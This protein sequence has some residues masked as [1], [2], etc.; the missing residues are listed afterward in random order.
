MNK[1]L[2]KDPRLR[3]LLLALAAIVVILAALFIYW[4]G[5]VHGEGV[6][7]ELVVILLFLFALFGAIAV[8][9]EFVRSANLGQ[10]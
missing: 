2:C 6:G 1:Q 9:G 8:G 4:R 10:P 5:M 7:Y 3:R